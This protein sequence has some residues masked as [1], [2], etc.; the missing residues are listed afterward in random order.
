MVLDLIYTSGKVWV[1]EKSKRRKIIDR[2]NFISNPINNQQTNFFIQNKLLY[3]FY[4][5]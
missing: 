1:L 2:F 5:Q 3:M 4:F